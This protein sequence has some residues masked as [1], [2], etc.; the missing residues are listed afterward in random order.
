MNR[1][2]ALILTLVSVVLCGCPG[3]LA[4]F[5]G[6]MFAIVSA[7]PGAEIDIA[8]SND[9][10]AALAVGSGGICLGLIFIAIPIAVWFFILRR[11]SATTSL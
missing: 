11:S 5:M 4:L 8:G 9:P 10:A 6:L 3:I 1:N 2:T 7:I